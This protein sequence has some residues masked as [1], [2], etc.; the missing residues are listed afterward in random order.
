M[1][2][3]KGDMI[4]VAYDEG[5]LLVCTLKRLVPN[6]IN[7]M[8]VCKCRR[9]MDPTELGSFVGALKCPSCTQGYLLP[10]DPVDSFSNWKCDRNNSSYNNDTNGGHNGDNNK[11]P[12]TSKLCRADVPFPASMSN[13][14][15]RTNGGGKCNN[16]EEEI[17]DADFD[18]E[19]ITDMILDAES[20]CG[21]SA[22]NLGLDPP[23]E[24]EGILPLLKEFVEDYTG[25][26]LHPNHYILQEVN[27]RIIKGDYAK[28]LSTLSDLE[29]T[30]FLDRCERLLRVADLLTPGYCEYRGE[31]AF[32]IYAKCYFVCIDMKPS[33]VIP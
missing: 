25:T 28:G 2:I 23:A 4:S 5:Q 24:D 19:S 31:S 27:V 26:I 15:E 1:P 21:Y 12:V 20:T 3:A 17:C 7:G 32:S 18:D 10:I 33:Y 11:T 29:L 9:C 8:F 22:I 6:E 30:Q 13:V 14:S 16:N